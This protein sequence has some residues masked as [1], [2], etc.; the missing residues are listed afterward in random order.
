MMKNKNILALAA[1]LAAWLAL[2][3][4][5][6]LAQ[7]Q[8]GPSFTLQHSPAAGSQ[9]TASKAAA[10]GVRNV[11]DCIVATFAGNASLAAASTAN[12]V[13]RDGATGAGTVIWQGTMSVP[14]TAGSAAAPIVACPVGGL[15][16][17]GTAGVAMTV[18]FSAGVANVL[19][20]VYLKGHVER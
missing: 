13:V 20:A 19:E 10:T 2:S 3:P 11:A 12:V 17:S 8:S 16:L 4:P 1:G 15:G 14:A 6:A 18:E 5:A 7:N 9:A